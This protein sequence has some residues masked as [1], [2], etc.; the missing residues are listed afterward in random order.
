MMCEVISSC[1]LCNL[2]WR[3][4]VILKAAIKHLSCNVPEQLDCQKVRS[5]LLNQQTDLSKR[6]VP[7]RVNFVNFETDV[8]ATHFQF[9]LCTRWLGLVKHFLHLLISGL[10]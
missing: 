6:A 1:K 10:F 3:Y 8:S 7:L 5:G 4:F 9:S 2:K